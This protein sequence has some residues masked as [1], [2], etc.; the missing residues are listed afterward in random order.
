MMLSES[1]RLRSAAEARFRVQAPNSTP[2]AVKVI[3]LDADGA[4]VVRRL[5]GAAWAHATFFTAVPGVRLQ[6]DHLDGPADQPPPRL[7]RSA[8]AS[9]TAEAGSHVDASSETVLSDL[10]GRLRNLAEEIETADLIV[11]VAGPGGH[12]QH[13][14]F[15]GQACSRQRVMT[16]G[17]IVGAASASESSLSKTL[18][19]VRPWSL[20]TV[21]ANSDDYIDD[22]MTALRA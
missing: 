3:A 17:F 12:A 6:A 18:A 13:A 10:A 11:L 7:R 1:T 20:M 15:I 4:A 16:T 22:M 19:Q 5:A 9:A 8:E 14:T 21:I 2:H